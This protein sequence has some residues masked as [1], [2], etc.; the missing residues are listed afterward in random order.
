LTPPAKFN[1]QPESTGGKTKETM[2][3][4]LKLIHAVTEYDRKQSRKPGYNRYA[5]PQYLERV[6]LICKDIDAGAD[7]SRA[8]KSGFSGRIADAIG[9]LYYRPVAAKI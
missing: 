8:I 6:D 2:N 9:G 7:A 5:L 3:T 4:K 1:H